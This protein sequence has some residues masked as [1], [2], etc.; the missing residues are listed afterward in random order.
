MKIS[1]KPSRSGFGSSADRT[2]A[3]KPTIVAAI[4][5]KKPNVPSRIPTSPTHKDGGADQE[6]DAPPAPSAQSTIGGLGF[7]EFVEFVSR[8]AVEGMQQEN[9][10]VVF[11]TPFSKVL[12]MLTVW[13]VADM[14]KLEEVRVIHTEEVYQ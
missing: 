3:V 8:V 6:E 4:S 7:S 11:P 10:D 2:K 1:T 13:G 5:P 14:R 9:Y 12:A